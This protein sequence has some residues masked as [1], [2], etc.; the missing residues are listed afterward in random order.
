MEKWKPCP[1]SIKLLL[2]PGIKF[3]IKT[4]QKT[5]KKV[6]DLTFNWTLS[7]LRH[8]YNKNWHILTIDPQ[9]FMNLIMSPLK[10]TNMYVA[11]LEVIKLTAIQN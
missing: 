4:Q 9:P 3:G 10:W 7:D 6:L 2:F 5:M 8:I 11:L 1:T